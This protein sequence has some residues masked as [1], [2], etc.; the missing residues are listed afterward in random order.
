MILFFILP[1]QIILIALPFMKNTKTA[2]LYFLGFLLISTVFFGAQYLLKEQEILNL[3]FKIH[4]FIF[5]VSFISLA[6]ILS[7]FAFG[8]TGWIGF[9]FLGFVLFKIIAI[10]YIAIKEPEFQKNLISYFI[11]YWLYLAIEVVYV[12]KLVKKQD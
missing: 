5:F 6:T 3:D 12:V 7:V 4:F 9:F 1:I 10:A 11:L 2:L 8:K